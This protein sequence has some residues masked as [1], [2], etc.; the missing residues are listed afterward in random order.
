MF[1]DKPVPSNRLETL[2]KILI[3]KN[4]PSL[5]DYTLNNLLAPTSLPEFEGSHSKN[6]ISAGKEIG[7]INYVENSK[8]IKKLSSNGKNAKEFLLEY[9]DDKVLSDVT[10]EPYFA[11]FYSYVLSREIPLTNDA[12]AMTKLT[13]LAREDIAGFRG[14]NRFNEV[15][16]RSYLPWYFYLGLTQ[17][18]KKSSPITSETYPYERIKRKLKDIFTTSKKLPVDVFMEHLGNSCPELDNGEIFCSVNSNQGSGERTIT[19]GVSNVLIELHMNGHIVLDCPLDS[20]GWNFHSK[21]TIASLPEGL[22]STKILS[23][24]FGLKKAKS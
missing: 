21:V 6:I 1:M 4:M 9:L 15:K 10:V 13:E 17:V 5:C 11:R 2:A 23:V 14:N 3:A 7:L 18:N 20:D 8:K 24:S 22:K 12:E 19:L 16:L